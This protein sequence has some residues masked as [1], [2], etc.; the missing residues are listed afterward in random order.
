MQKT[1]QVLKNYSYNIFKLQVLIFIMPPSRTRTG[2][3]E[4]CYD[5]QVVIKNLLPVQISG[6]K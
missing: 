3:G 4:V 6:I 5:S 1:F 2:T